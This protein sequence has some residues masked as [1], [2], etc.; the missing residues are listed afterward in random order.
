MLLS[1]ADSDPKMTR[2]S[3]LLK[4][5][6]AGTQRGD[7]QPQSAP[8]RQPQAAKWPEIIG[9][10]SGTQ[11]QKKKKNPIALVLCLTKQN[12]WPLYYRGH[13]KLK[14]LTI[15]KVPSVAPL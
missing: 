12:L 15:E 10:R 4:K 5:A 7:T 2:E 8:T 9:Y 6:C 11:I 13:S 3:T 14:R 1:G